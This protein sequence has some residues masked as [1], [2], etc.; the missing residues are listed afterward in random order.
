MVVVVNGSLGEVGRARLAEVAD[1]V[2]V[3]ENRGFDVWALKAG[4]DRVGAGIG[5]F[6]EVLL[7]NDTW[8]GPVGSFEG[9]F[10]RMDAREVHFWG[11]TDHARTVPNPLTGEGVL[12]YHLQSYWLAVRRE[13]FL[14]EAW[15]AYW[16]DLPQMPGYRDAVLRHEVVFTEHFTG[17]GF[18]AGVAFPAE[19]YPTENPSLLNADL[20]V[21]DGCPV[22][23]RRVFF[24]WPPFLHR[25]AVVGRWVLDAM[26][27]AGYPAGLALTDL[28]RNVPPRVLNANLGL[29][30]VLPDTATGYDPTHPLRIAAILHVFYVEMTEEMLDRVDLLPGAVDVMI[31]TSHRARADAIEEIVA[32][33]P[34]RGRPVSV[35]VV[36]SNAGRDQSAFYIGCRDLL[37]GGGYDLVVKL[38][39]KKTPQDGYN[40][41]RH[42]KD[43]QFANLL[44]NE[45]FAASLVGLFQREPELGIV[46]PPMIHVGYP[47]F[48]HA[49]WANRPGVEALAARLGIRVPLDEASPLAPYGSMFVARP[50]A[51]HLLTAAPWTYDDFGGPDSYRDGGPAHVLERMPSYAAG[52][53][54]FHTRTVTTAE[55]GAISHTSIEF[56]LDR[57][58]STTPGDALARIE[59]RERLRP[60]GLDDLRALIRTD[61]R[62]NRPRT[63]RLVRRAGELVSRIR[64]LARRLTPGTDEAVARDRRA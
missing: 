30:E 8:F 5:A 7:T 23:K 58:S 38:H 16:R 59:L 37:L 62:L 57:I 48:G 42:F 51:L 53:Q 25:H 20:L 46:Y 60:D 26:T 2:V 32:A 56:L 19:E 40:V 14:S 31:T 49:W 3:R 41:G 61:L 50:E 9:V 52:E 11:L 15:A 1:D 43:Q 17:L 6:D 54:G 10:A 29:L 34:R 21:R 64:R 44:A 36:D 35:R 12:P 18:V 33:R 4:L 63:A 22:V 27:R 39:S 24:Q 45:G 13:M 28:A 55:Y 47:T